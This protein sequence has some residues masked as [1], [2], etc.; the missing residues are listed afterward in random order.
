MSQ[1]SVEE[2][3]LPGDTSRFAAEDVW[4]AAQD[5]WEYCPAY[6]DEEFGIGEAREHPTVDPAQ[7]TAYMV[8]ACF[9]N[10]DE[11][12]D[13]IEISHAGKA[14]F[15]RWWEEVSV[16]GASRV[17][18]YSPRRDMAEYFCRCIAQ[19]KQVALEEFMH[20]GMEDLGDGS[21]DWQWSE[22]FGGG[23]R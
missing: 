16:V 19:L 10:V 4:Q 9:T 23:P 12:P 14:E 1:E 15:I 21:V 8:W 18:F 5:F 13:P 17:V 2:Y 20:R 11:A 3:R 22:V 7:K 6:R